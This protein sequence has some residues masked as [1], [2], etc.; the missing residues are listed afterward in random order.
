[1]VLF[2]ALAV[3]ASEKNKVTKKQSTTIYQVLLP[4]EADKVGNSCG[5]A[6]GTMANGK[7]QWLGKLRSN[8]FPKG[9]F[10]NFQEAFNSIEGFS[11]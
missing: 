11:G 6:Y 3:Q 2:L 4:G 8:K 9:C 10:S 1:V 5:K 7:I